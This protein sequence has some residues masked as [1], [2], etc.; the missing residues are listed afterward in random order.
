L[1]RGKNKH[2]IIYLLYSHSQAQAE[3]MDF[4]FILTLIRIRLDLNLK[5]VFPIKTLKLTKSL[6]NREWG[7][8][9][10]MSFTPVVGLELILGQNFINSIERKVFK[11]I[12]SLNRCIIYP[13]SVMQ[14]FVV[15]F[16][17]L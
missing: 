8:Q 11:K 15:T 4:W 16:L 7:S 3:N 17:F 2:D 6:Q 1:W 12:A 5:M 14:Q 9:V 10:T 13:I